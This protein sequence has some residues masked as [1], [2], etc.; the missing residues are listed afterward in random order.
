[1]QCVKRY[2]TFFMVDLCFD[3]SYLS[4]PFM[5]WILKMSHSLF[6][7]SGA[8]DI[9]TSSKWICCGNKDVLER[10]YAWADKLVACYTCDCVLAVFVCFFVPPIVLLHCGFWLCKNWIEQG[11]PKKIPVSVFELKSVTYV[12]VHS[13]SYI[14]PRKPKYPKTFY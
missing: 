12:S 4:G 14:L 7:V 1:M 10:G 3:A 5:N 11:N 6:D 13:Q 9:Y 2:Q 8:A